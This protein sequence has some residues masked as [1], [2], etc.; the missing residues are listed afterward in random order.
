M[1][2]YFHCLIMLIVT[3]NYLRTK[4]LLEIIIEDYSRSFKVNKK[5]RLL[6]A[7]ALYNY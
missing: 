5:N 6:Q 7:S 3:I 1:V 2:N 4:T